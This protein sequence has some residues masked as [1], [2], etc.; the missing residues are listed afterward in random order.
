MTCVQSHAHG[1]SGW[2]QQTTTDLHIHD[3]VGE[4]CEVFADFFDWRRVVLLL[5][6]YEVQFERWDFNIFVV[7]IVMFLLATFSRVWTEGPLLWCI[8]DLLEPGEVRSVAEVASAPPFWS[9]IVLLVL[10]LVLA[11]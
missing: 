11:C 6:V 7:E 10:S 8:V 1:R 3:F 5:R 4:G 2:W 9:Q